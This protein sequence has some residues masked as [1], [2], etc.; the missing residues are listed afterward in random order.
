MAD[1]FTYPVA[2]PSGSVSLLSV[3][4]SPTTRF[5]FDTVTPFGTFADNDTMLVESGPT[6]FWVWLT[7]AL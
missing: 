1:A 3:I 4:L 5:Q 2:L 7:S 6:V